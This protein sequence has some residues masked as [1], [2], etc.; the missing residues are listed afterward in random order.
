MGCNASISVVENRPSNLQ[1]DHQIVPS[2]KLDS[3]HC[4]S[5]D[6]IIKKLKATPNWTESGVEYGLLHTGGFVRVA[7]D[8]CRVYYLAQNTTEHT[9]PDWKFH[10][11]VCFADLPV[12]W[13]II[14]KLFIESGCCSGMKMC[15]CNAE[16]Y[17]GHW[18]VGQYGREITIYIYQHMKQYKDLIVDDPKLKLTRKLE[19]SPKFWKKLVQTI[20]T[21]LSNHNIKTNGLADGDYPI[22]K[23]VSIRNEA[24]VKVGTELVYPPNNHGYNAA[25]HKCPIKLP[26]W[27]PPIAALTTE[28]V[29]SDLVGGI[30][31]HSGLKS[32]E[33]IAVVESNLALVKVETDEME[34]GLKDVVLANE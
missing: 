4:F 25:N 11:S 3:S 33:V 18:S 30:I 8:V 32:R 31:S 22:N 13:D 7:T 2:D 29:S 14:V 6:S 34:V 10:V 15:L 17:F 26:H 23:Y 20:A 21:A 9:T 24:Y 27:V 19:H 1:T 28:V 5:F 12:A 16:N